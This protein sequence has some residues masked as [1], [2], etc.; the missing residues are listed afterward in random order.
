MLKLY[1]AVRSR[2]AIVQWY[3][4]EYQIPYELVMLD[5]QA[6]EHRQPAYLAIN[7]I[8]KVPAIVDD[9]FILWESGA[10]LLYL[11]E[12]YG[13]LPTTLPE[14]AIA[15]QWVLYANATL[16]PALFIEANREREMP[17]Q[18][19]AID[20]LLAQQPFLLGEEFSVVDV[21]VGSM[22]IYGTTLLKLDFSP[23]PA[24]VDYVT[25]LM[26]RQQR[27]LSRGH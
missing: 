27:A 7:P 3:L 16:G 22:L 20:R 14:R 26:E 1:G 4:E 12:K 6:G 23:Y 2:S 8:G 5:M 18:L 19:P 13:H 9:G 15:T 21:A 17:K 10:I 25:R 24:I 11:A